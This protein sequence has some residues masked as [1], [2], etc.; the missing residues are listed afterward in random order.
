MPV[1]RSAIL[2]TAV[3]KG[4]F[5]AQGQGIGSYTLL[6]LKSRLNKTPRNFSHKNYVLAYWIFLL[7]DASRMRWKVFY[8]ISPW[9]NWLKAFFI[10]ALSRQRQWLAVTGGG[11]KIWCNQITTSSMDFFGTSCMFVC[12]AQLVSS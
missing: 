5:P 11:Q 1:R 3:R 6:I 8:A 7:M 12:V 9:Y 4:Q 10:V 2:N